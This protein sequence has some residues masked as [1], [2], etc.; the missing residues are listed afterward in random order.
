MTHQSHQSDTE[1]SLEPVAAT[2]TLTSRP[3]TA[4]STSGIKHLE[5]TKTY[6]QK[7]LEIR[8]KFAEE[9]HQYI[10]EYIRLADQKATFFFAG[11]TA[12]LAYL[13]SLGFVNSWLTKPS[14]WRL[15]DVLACVSTI[16]LIA[17]A[18]AF[19]SAVIPRTSGSRR[20]LVFFGA[21][22]EYENSNQYATDIIKSDLQELYGS[23]L[24]H[25]YDISK[26]CTRKYG[27]LK[28]GQWIGIGAVIAFMLLLVA[29]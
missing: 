4:D 1:T 5:S 25:N 23:K 24:M 29:K 6:Q 15:V 16:G 26:V 9:T 27:M 13:N 8:L 2:A 22:A 28:W 21:I 7:E 10:R 17:S 19:A 11:S 3:V 18:V 12:L 14:T 20:G